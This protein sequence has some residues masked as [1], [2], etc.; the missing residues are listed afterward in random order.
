MSSDSRQALIRRSTDT[1][2]MPPPPTKRIKRP[3]KVLDEDTYTDALSKIIARDFFPGLLETQTQQ[4]YLDALESQNSEWIASAGRKL[5]EVMTPGP[6][7]ARR[8]TS[9][10][11]P[12]PSETPRG[13]GGDTPVS[14]I[15]TTESQATQTPE[16]DLNMSLDGFQAKYTSEDNESFNRLLDKQNLKR[17]GKY[18]W[19]WAGNKIPAPRQI[20]QREREGKL[21]QAKLEQ[22]KEDGGKP[23]LLIEG[24]DERKAMPDT[25]NAKPNNQVFFTPDSVED[26]YETVQQS[27]EAKSRAPPKAV[28]YG[29]T[30]LAPPPTEPDPAIPPSPS[31]SAIQDAIAGRPRATDSEPGY[32]GGQTPRVNGYAFVDDEPTPAEE[33]AAAAASNDAT[34][35]LGS[36]DATPNPFKIKEQS[37]RESLLHRMVDRVNKNNRPMAR[38]AVISGGNGGTPTPKFGSSPKV[39]GGGGGGGNLTPAGQKLLSRVASPQNGGVGLFERKRT[40]TGVRQKE[41]GLRYR[42][43]PTP[44]VQSRG[45]KD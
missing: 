10:A 5:T 40:G 17:G 25:W 4:E 43:T 36:G 1:E 33:A 12:R 31:I 28:A 8:G 32:S 22:E 3:P 19:L 13:Y 26:D 34:L 35:L 6:G 41:S 45:I 2:L 38:R 23:R 29:N 14:V 24:P 21:L 39:G 27:A 9:L 16:V 11:T 30:R 15:S 20:M 37:K 42:W 18:R 7:R 44:K